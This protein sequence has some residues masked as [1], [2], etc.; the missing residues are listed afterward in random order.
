MVI[1]IVT[2]LINGK[3]YIGMDS[4]NNPE[5]L[6]SGYQIK[7]AIEKYGRSNF[8]KD[9]LETCL[10]LEELRER[11]IYW[12]NK[13]SAVESPNFYNLLGTKTP[14]QKG[15]TRTLE[16]RAK[17]SHTKQEYFRTHAGSNAG[18]TFPQ[19]VRDKI[20]RSKKGTKLSKETR[21]KLSEVRKGRKCTW[22]DKIAETKKGTP[23]SKVWKPVEQYDL[24]GNLIKTYPGVSVAKTETG[25]N[26]IY[27]NLCGDCKTAGG[28]VWKYAN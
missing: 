6:G 13:F 16:T 19:E 12:I 26:S 1:Y 4:A 22:G 20:S 10:T 18:R 9:I 15:R 23:N 27:S 5:Y 11:E 3:K 24:Q 14:S 17:I 2:N 25:I 21:E 8:K 7:K 28:Y